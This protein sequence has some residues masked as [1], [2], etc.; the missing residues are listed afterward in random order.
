M[1]ARSRSSEPARRKKTEPH[2]R[3]SIWAVL[4]V[5]VAGLFLVGSLYLLLL[6]R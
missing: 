3:P 6:V 4:L 5:V 1:R 2:S